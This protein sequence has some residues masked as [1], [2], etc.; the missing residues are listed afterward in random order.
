MNLSGHSVILPLSWDFIL[1]CVFMSV[2]VMFSFISI[3]S[4][5]ILI[6]VSL[7]SESALLLKGRTLDILKLI[8]FKFTMA[9]GI[10]VE[11]FTVSDI[12]E[13]YSWITIKV[14]STAP[15]RPERL[16]IS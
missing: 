14:R 1:D 12:L 2:A 7:T 13:L 4:L 5:A 3:P 6:S 11:I 10:Y 15:M 9:E 16:E 8:L